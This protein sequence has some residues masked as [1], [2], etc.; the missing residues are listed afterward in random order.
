MKK[1]LLKTAIFLVLLSQIALALD[2]IDCFKY[3]EYG[4]GVVFR[5]LMTEQKSYAPGE[6]AVITYSVL[7]QMNAPI[8]EGSVRMDVFYNDPVDGEQLIDEFYAGEN[9]NLMKGSQAN[10]RIVWNVPLGARSGDY[11]LK[12]YFVVGKYFNLAGLTGA[13]YGAPAEVV[14]FQVKE[15]ANPDTLYFSK[16]DTTVN[17]EAYD[18]SAPPRVYDGTISLKTKLVNVGGAKEV[19]VRIQSYIWDDLKDLPLSQYT[20]EKTVTLQANGAQDISYDLSGLSAATYEITLSA[21]TEESKALMKVRAPVGGAKGMILYLGLDKFPLAKDDETSVFACYSTATDYSTSFTGTLKLEVLDEKGNVIAQDTGTVNMVPT[22]P[23]GK[24]VSFKPT[25][26]QKTVTVRASLWDDKNGLQDTATV[27][28][29]YSDYIGEKGE[30]SL[31]VSPRT[32][33]D[34]SDVTYT[35]T[36]KDNAGTP[37]NGKIIVYASDPKDKV[38]GTASDVEIKGQYTGKFRVTGT[39]GD[40]KIT[41]RELS[42][43]KKVEGSF[44][45][46]VMAEA[47]TTTEPPAQNPDETTTTEPPAAPADAQPNYPLIIGAVV[48]IALIAILLMRRKKK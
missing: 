30:L 12:T 45:V 27:T 48:V 43:D 16:K 2:D 10:K 22:P 41:V 32:I 38:I 31:T 19:K 4:T 9:I 18:F 47:T 28:Y 34:G 13:P 33:T 26:A 29:D 24:K 40:Y 39:L 44:K 15:P 20:Q 1:N 8:T 5:E 46:G 25:A 17:G 35:V 36:Y 7:S 42:S 11:T 23:Q 14:N 6:P 3:Y 37:L 21:Q